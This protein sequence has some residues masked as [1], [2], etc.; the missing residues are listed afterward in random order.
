MLGSH[1]SRWARSA[2]RARL[3]ELLGG[4]DTPAILFTASHGVEFANGDA[5]QLLHQGALLCQDWPGPLQWDKPIPE[6]HYLSA[7]DVG[8][9]SP[10]QRMISE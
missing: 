2:S 8:S 4:A 7:D 3:Q 5:K 10:S 6:E 9:S 1:G